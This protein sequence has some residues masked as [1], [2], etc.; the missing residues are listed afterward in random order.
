MDVGRER[1]HPVG[2]PLHRAPE[3]DREEAGGDVVGIAVDLEPEAPADVRRDDPQ[4]LL[5]DGEDPREDR[6]H[7]VGDL[8][9]DPHR[10]RLRGGLVGGDEAPGLEG[11]ARLAPDHEPLAIDAGGLGE[12]PVDL[13]LVEA[14]TVDDVVARFL[15]DE[16]GAGAHRGLGIDDRGE[17]LVVHL[18][19]VAGVLGD[20]A[21][22][23]RDGD[24]GLA[25]VADLVDC[26]RVLQGRLHAHVVGEDPPPRPAAPGGLLAGEDADDARQGGGAA[27]VHAAEAGVGMRALH[28]RRGDHAGEPEIV[29]VPALAGQQAR[30]LDALHRLADRL[31]DRSRALHHRTA[32]RSRAA[33]S[34]TASTIAWYPVQRQMFPASSRRISSR[35]G[36][37]ARRRRS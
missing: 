9:G 4:L 3:L 20:V 10:H 12:R 37:G 15:V 5:L 28:E 19:Q 1:L 24:D 32:P 18:D 27:H 26:E 13:A 11:H 6:L 29:H 2:D 36:S 33:A 16:R 7:H 21:V 14:A 17:R 23:R 35:L 22:H 34:S 30:V 25:H 8:A 31:R